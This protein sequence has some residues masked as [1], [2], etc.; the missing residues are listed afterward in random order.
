MVEIELRVFSPLAGVF[1]RGIPQ[2]VK[3]HYATRKI[4][5]PFRSSDFS[6]VL[7]IELLN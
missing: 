1:S 5:T 7:V 2:I 6:L 3:L 4:A